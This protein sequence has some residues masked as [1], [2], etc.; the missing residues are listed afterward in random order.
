MGITIPSNKAIRIETPY[1]AI[2]R[3]P[4]SKYDVGAPA[5]AGHPTVNMWAKFKPQKVSPDTPAEISEATRKANN[6]GLSCNVA[7]PDVGVPKAS[8][9]NVAN[10]VWAYDPPGTNDFKRLTDW[11][12][13]EAD[14][15]PPVAPTEP[16]TVYG[17]SSSFTYSQR[18]QIQSTN[19]LKL[20]DFSYLADKYLCF[21]IYKSG[22]TAILGGFTAPATIGSGAVGSMTLAYPPTAGGTANLG[23]LNFSGADRYV[24]CAADVVATTTTEFASK[25][26]RLY[27]LP[28]ADG[29]SNVF[30][31]TTKSP[32]AVRFVKVSKTKVPFS[33]A[34]NIDDYRFAGMDPETGE[35][36][37]KYFDCTNGFWV[38]VEIHN[39]ANFIPTLA[40]GNVLMHTQKNLVKTFAIN[41]KATFAPVLF[42][43]D[44][45]T[46]TPVEVSR[47][48]LSP[49]E[50]ALLCFNIRTLAYS[51]GSA[52]SNAVI[53][54]KLWF[55]AT[56][57]WA[58]DTTGTAG[59]LTMYIDGN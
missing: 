30:A 34:E 35:S 3:Q 22:S 57:G 21:A 17:T 18:Q 14:A 46:S 16:V 54:H 36:T 29:L 28:N 19:N 32:V 52:T 39:E 27:P 45:E 7:N 6:W 56:I 20:T 23:Q 26:N 2:D 42:K 47:V 49:G 31:F 4:T 48:S 41:E 58:N 38:Y 11:L 50:K 33:Q 12:G 5:A 43:C 37:A 51:T 25:V 59:T 44:S 15:A 9:A 40:T 13:Y 24:L 55:N 53:N 1:V 8:G 10:T